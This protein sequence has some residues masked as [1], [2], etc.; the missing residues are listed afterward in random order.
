[1]YFGSEESGGCFWEFL[2]DGMGLDADSRFKVKYDDSNMI[3]FVKRK[4][5]RHLG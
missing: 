5:D 1:M 2:E 3:K 4:L